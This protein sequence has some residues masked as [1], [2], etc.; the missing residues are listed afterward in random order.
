MRTV[1]GHA[2]DVRIWQ[3]LSPNTGHPHQCAVSRGQ[4]AG[5][6]KPV[7]NPVHAVG[8]AALCTLKPEGGWVCPPWR[9]GLTRKTMNVPEG[10]D[11]RRQQWVNSLNEKKH[12]KGPAAHS[13]HPIPSLIKHHRTP[14]PQGSGALFVNFHLFTY[15]FTYCH[16]RS[17][18]VSW[19]ALWRSKDNFGKR[20]SPS[21]VGSGDYTQVAR[22]PLEALYP[23]PA[24]QSILLV[25]ILAIIHNVC[26]SLPNL[27]FTRQCL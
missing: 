22:V 10:V 24:C 20:F 16:R 26:I 8:D 23:E 19:S 3:E 14:H 25:L 1:W 21:I 11:L 5:S 13:A 7:P 4:G 6:G 17:V 12:L 15:L 9:L 18:K 2:G 27:I